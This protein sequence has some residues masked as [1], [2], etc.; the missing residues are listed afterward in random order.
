MD[1][2]GDVKSIFGNFVK[3][4]SGKKVWRKISPNGQR[5]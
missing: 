2:K 1:S 5:M 4:T 3:R